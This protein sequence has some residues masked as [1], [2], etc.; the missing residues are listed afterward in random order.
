MELP[1]N[2]SPDREVAIF[3]AALPLDGEPRASYLRQACAG[4]DALRVRHGWPLLTRAGS[5]DGKATERRLTATVAGPG[6][7]RNWPGGR[8]S[9]AGSAAQQNGPGPRVVREDRWRRR[10]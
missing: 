9:V 6:T 8:G 1:M 3:N 5:P 10:H 7:S 4:N 2:N